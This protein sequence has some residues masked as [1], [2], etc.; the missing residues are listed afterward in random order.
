MQLTKTNQSS[1]NIDEY[2]EGFYIL[3]VET[4]DGVYTEKVF[5]N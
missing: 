1:V 4:L 3:R 2:P 5:M